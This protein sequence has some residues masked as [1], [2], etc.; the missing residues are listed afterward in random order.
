MN[1][2]IFQAPRFVV[3]SSIVAMDALT[4]MVERAKAIDVQTG[5]AKIAVTHSDYPDHV[6]EHSLI[7]GVIARVDTGENEHIN[8][9]GVVSAKIAKMMRTGQPT[10]GRDDDFEGEVPYRGGMILSRNKYIIYVAYSGGTEDE[11]VEISK[12]GAQVMKNL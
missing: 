11:D 8:Y 12:V 5:V 2:T 7:N 3:P 9:A 4:Q 1:F 6:L 10:G